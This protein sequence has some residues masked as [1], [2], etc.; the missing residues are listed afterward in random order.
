M[1]IEGDERMRTMQRLEISPRC[2]FFS[3]FFFS[4]LLTIFTGLHYSIHVVMIA[5]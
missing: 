4:Y 2:V 1:E 3:L 5:S